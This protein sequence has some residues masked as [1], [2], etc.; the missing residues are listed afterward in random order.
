[1]L[2][3][4]LKRAGRPDLLARRVANNGVPWGK[5]FA[6]A[7]LPTF[8]QQKLNPSAT[9]ATSAGGRLGD[10]AWM[11]GLR[12]GLSILVMT[13]HQLQPFGRSPSVVFG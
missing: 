4:T 3:D 10:T 6:Y 8:V 9:S 13:F 5:R 7:L 1:M 12:G 11:D 2:T